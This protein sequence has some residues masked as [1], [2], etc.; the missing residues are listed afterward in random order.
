MAGATCGF[1]HLVFLS[2]VKAQDRLQCESP[3]ALPAGG[4]LYGKVK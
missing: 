1:D 2:P 4:W 3:L